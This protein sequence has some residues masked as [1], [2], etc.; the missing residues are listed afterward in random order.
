MVIRT[1][2]VPLGVERARD[3]CSIVR[4]AFDRYRGSQLLRVSTDGM[5]F[6]GVVGRG[7]ALSGAVSGGG[8]PWISAILK[9]F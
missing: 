1:R 7:T 5:S 4:S 2:S 3:R 8:I 9:M 6:G